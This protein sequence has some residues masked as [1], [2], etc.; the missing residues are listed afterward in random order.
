M[1]DICSLDELKTIVGSI[2]RQYGVRRVCLFGSYA[3][4][5]ATE[6][7]D[8]DLVI[9]KGAIRGMFQYCAFIRS[10]EEALGKHVDVMTYATLESSG[11]GKTVTKEVLLYEQ[12]DTASA[13]LLA[14]LAKG[15]E[16]AR[17]DGWIKEEDVRAKLVQT[18]E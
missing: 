5:T 18:E 2:A 9:D 12:T 3:N 14:D 16:S 15:E 4:G 10:L 6:N 13:R 8:V 1:A 7:S 11:I 17:K